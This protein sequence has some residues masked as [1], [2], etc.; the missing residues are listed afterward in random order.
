MLKSLAITILMLFSIILSAQPTLVASAQAA[1]TCPDTYL[2][3]CGTVGGV[4]K[5]FRNECFARAAGATHLVKGACINP[6]R[7]CPMIYQ[8]VCA[9]KFGVRRTYSNSCEANRAGA[10]DISTG[11]CLVRPTR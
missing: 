5:P 7:F 11:Q 1:T 6:I 8:P 4:Q 2:P 9:I 3:I 10:T